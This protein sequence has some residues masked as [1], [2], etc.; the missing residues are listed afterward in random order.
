MP[1]LIPDCLH[2][3]SCKALAAELKVIM[4]LRTRLGGRFE[5]CC[6]K[7]MA[8]GCD[9][10]G[11]NKPQSDC[12]QTASLATS[13]Q[14]STRRQNANC[15]FCKEVQA[16]PCDEAVTML[17]S[18]VAKMTAPEFQDLGSLPNRPASTA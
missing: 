12:V 4:S 13:I 7:Y 17:L 14:P 16:W 1:Q 3:L 8:K 11:S 18:K 9:T 6:K 10:Q 2:K 15:M 5:T